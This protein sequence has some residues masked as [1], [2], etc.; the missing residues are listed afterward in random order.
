LRSLADSRVIFTGAIYGEGY[1]A[2]QRDAGMFIFACEVGGIHP[3]LIETMACGNAAL[4]LDTESNRETANGCGLMFSRDDQD[5][6]DKI[7]RLL[8][9]PLLREQLGQT[10]ADY[11]RRT[12]GW[13]EVTRKYEAL[14]EEVLK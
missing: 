5:L 14:F 3:A 13:D 7:H 10:A 11:A 6:A 12:Y 4:Y 2:L 8:A 1:W 9:D